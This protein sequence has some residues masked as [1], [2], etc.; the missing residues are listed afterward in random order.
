MSSFSR[1]QQIFI[2]QLRPDM[3]HHKELSLIEEALLKSLKS[4]H[5][6]MDMPATKTTYAIALCKL[7]YVYPKH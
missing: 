6:T 1:S 5:A 2:S 7:C 3:S 4:H